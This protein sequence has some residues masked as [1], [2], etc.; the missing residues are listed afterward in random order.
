MS[1]CSLLVH[2]ICPISK[3]RSSHPEVFLGKEV[4]KI[5]NEFLGEHP[6]RSAIS[7]K[8][9]SIF[10]EVTLQHGCLPVNLLHNF[11]IPFPKNTSGR[12]PLKIL[13]QV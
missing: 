4:L 5:C 12:L 7:I 1:F 10:I 6:F 9:Q 2:A 3:Y 13:S 11:R 8:L